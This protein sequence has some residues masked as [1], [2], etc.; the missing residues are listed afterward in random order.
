MESFIPV[1]DRATNRTPVEHVVVI[2][3]ENHAFDNYF[4]TYPGADGIPANVSLPDGQ[5]GV[6]APHPLNATWTW[7]LPHSRE[8][9]LQS[10][11]GGKNDGFAMAAS[12]WF[13][14][15]GEIAMGYYDRRQVGG[16]WSLAENYTLAD[17]YFQSM[18]GPTVP[19]RLYSFAGQAGGLTSNLIGS[20]G[21]DLPTIFDQLEAHQISWKYYSSVAPHY[22]PLPTNFPHIRD[23]F[24]MASKIVPLDLLVSDVATGNLPQVAYVDPESD[25]RI[26][27]HPPGDVAVGTAWTIQTIRAIQASPT[28]RSTA[29]LLTWDE[30]GGFYDHVAPPQVDEWGYGFRVPML[31]ISPFTRRGWIDH[32]VMDHTSLMKFIADNWGLPYLTDREAQ[33]GSPLGAFVFGPTGTVKESAPRTTPA[34]DPRLG[35]PQVSA[36]GATPGSRLRDPRR[37][38]DPC[39]RP[40]GFQQSTAVGWLAEGS[41]R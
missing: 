37:S 3:K 40:V 5:G 17:R 35:E 41:G 14:G 6:I 2:M 25:L 27:E 22:V 24:R 1:Q 32:I 33:A 23:N 38:G 11:D 26:S 34:Q 10:Y 18:F 19:N 15:L 39:F 28:W 21:L 13:P 8:A 29:V 20:S 7:D 9:M 4:G 12:A 16:Y 31:V 30:S 36:P